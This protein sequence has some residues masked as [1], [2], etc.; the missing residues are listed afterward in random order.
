MSGP[1]PRVTALVA[2][3]LFVQAACTPVSR[4]YEIHTGQIGCQE[5]NRHVHD[6]L[7]AM[8]MVITAFRL[9]NPGSDGY[10]RATKTD[11]RGIRNGEVRISCRADGVSIVAAQKGLSIGGEHEFERG[12]FL[13]VT[14]RA[15]LKVDRGRIAGEWPAEILAVT[16]APQNSPPVRKPARPVEKVVG[17]VVRLEPLRGFA[18]VLDF[19]ADLS[20][21]GILPVKVTVANGTGRSYEFDPRDIVLRRAGSRRRAHTLPVSAALRMLVDANREILIA[22]AREAG[23]ADG[24]AVDISAIDPMAPTELGDI[25]TAAGIIRERLLRG[26]LLR[27]AGR[28]EGYLYFEVAEYDRARITMIDTATGETEGFIVEF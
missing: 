6:A 19:E 15:R 12:V 28:F 21:A 5:A 27:A 25:R 11:S 13:S 18:S 2:S 17:L 8:G 20:R 9:A 24:V 14:A 23:A 1:G 22:A 3:L 10:V 7:V 16:P 26:G 4:S